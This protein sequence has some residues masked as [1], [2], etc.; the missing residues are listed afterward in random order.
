MGDWMKNGWGGARNSREYPSLTSPWAKQHIPPGTRKSWL[1][2]SILGGDLGGLCHKEALGAAGF[3]WGF[4]P[5]HGS[6]A[7][8]W[9]A[10]CL[11]AGISVRMRSERNA[12]VRRPVCTLFLKGMVRHQKG[13]LDFEALSTSLFRC[14]G[15]SYESCRLPQAATEA[16]KLEASRSRVGMAKPCHFKT[17]ICLY[18]LQ[19]EEISPSIK[20]CGWHW[21]AE[22][23]F[24]M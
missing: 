17:L 22:T 14:E 21:T 20:N 11:F 2:A 3:S 24:K 9:R 18:E 23:G 6:T 15:G 16:E 13:L 1:Q 4:L 7:F 5:S 19:R 8:I 12:F 10:C